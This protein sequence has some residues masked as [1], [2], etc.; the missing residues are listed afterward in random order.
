MEERPILVTDPNRRSPAAWMPKTPPTVAYAVR[1]VGSF[2]LRKAIPKPDHLMRLG[3]VNAVRPAVVVEPQPVLFVPWATVLFQSV[4]EHGSTVLPVNRIVDRRRLEVLIQCGCLLVCPIPTR[5]GLHYKSRVGDK[6]KP[7]RHDRAS[8]IL[9]MLETVVTPHPNLHTLNRVMLF[10][11]MERPERIFTP[12]APWILLCNASN[13][14]FASPIPEQRAVEHPATLL[15]RTK[16]KEP[17]LERGLLGKRRHQI[18]VTV[19]VNQ[20]FRKMRHVPTSASTEHQVPRWFKACRVVGQSM[21]SNKII[22][23]LLTNG[24]HVVASS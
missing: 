17:R 6:R 13:Q 24:S 16:A 4:S 22:P 3:H 21:S 19:R 15:K 1:L 8:R 23:F 14:P 11:Q 2:R 10:V 12:P 9:P 5:L 7:I 20:F 18:V